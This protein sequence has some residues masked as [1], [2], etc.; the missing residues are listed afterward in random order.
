VLLCP[1]HQVCRHYM[2]EGACPYGV[3]CRFIHP[4]APAGAAPAAPPAVAVPAPATPPG[5]A[6]ASPPAAATQQQDV[7]QVCDAWAALC[8][9]GCQP[10]TAWCQLLSNTPC[11]CARPTSCLL[12]Y[13]SAAAL[14]AYTVLMLK[15]PRTLLPPPPSPSLLQAADP[16]KVGPRRLPVFQQLQ[17]A[18]GSPGLR[19]AAA[20]AGCEGL[21]GTGIGDDSDPFGTADS[22]SSMACFLAAN[23]VLESPKQYQG[24][25]GSFD[26]MAAGPAGI[27]RPGG[28]L[29]AASVGAEAAAA[30]QAVCER[31]RAESEGAVGPSRGLGWEGLWR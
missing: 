10:Y 4:T 18:P 24:G 15:H 14:C 3:R 17:V 30:A 31:L 8:C 6:A 13:V 1:L 5:P 27:I 2:E 22:A 16:S 23:A 9:G 28:A 19:S 12:S 7:G 25:M 11:G 20:G 26:L 29:S 21:E